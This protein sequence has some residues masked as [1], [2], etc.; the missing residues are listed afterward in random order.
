MA[1][2]IGSLDVLAIIK[3]LC[4]TFSVV[5]GVAFASVAQGLVVSRTIEG[6]AR[7]PE[8]ANDMRFTMIIGIAM[9]ESLAIYCLL[10]SLIFLFVN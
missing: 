4:A 7:Q 6:M 8:A 3:V 9:I 10:V 5:A 1:E 2:F